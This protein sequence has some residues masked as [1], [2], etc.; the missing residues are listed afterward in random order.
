MF[1]LR[2]QASLDSSARRVGDGYGGVRTLRA[3]R[4]G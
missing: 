3:G 2:R 1:T 4:Q